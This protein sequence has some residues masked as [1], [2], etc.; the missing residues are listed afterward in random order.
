MISEGLGVVTEH[1]NMSG[2]PTVAVKV[3]YEVTRLWPYSL[4]ATRD[5]TNWLAEFSGVDFTFVL[6]IASRM[7][8]AARGNWYQTQ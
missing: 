3:P 6:P 7:P 8:V 1:T 4:P 5:A 2:T